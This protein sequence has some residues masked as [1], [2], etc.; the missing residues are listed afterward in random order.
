[1][2]GEHG[3]FEVQDTQ[4]RAGVFV[5]IGVVA[6]GLIARGER[7]PPGSTWRDV[8]A[9]VAIIRPRICSTRRCGACSASTSRRKD[10][11]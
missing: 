5:H 1:L 10:R 9:Y 6:E 3:R 2:A 7:V 4:K 8:S 11:W